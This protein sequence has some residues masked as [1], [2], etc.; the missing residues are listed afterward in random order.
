MTFCWANTYLCRTWL[1]SVFHLVGWIINGRCVGHVTRPKFPSIDSISSGSHRMLLCT[2]CYCSRV[3][4]YS[5]HVHSPTS[6]GP[7]FWAAMLSKPSNAPLA[8]WIT[9]WFN[10]LGQ[11]AVTTGIRRVT[12]DASFS[13]AHLVLP[14]L[15]LRVPPSSRLPVLLGP[16]SYRA[17]RP[18]LGYTQQFSLPRVQHLNTLIHQ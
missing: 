7:Y 5:R 14:E 1:C 10:L 8:S 15:V 17:P 6:G 3:I 2:V 13:I 18:T 16:V 12:Y 9:G 11:V 4:F